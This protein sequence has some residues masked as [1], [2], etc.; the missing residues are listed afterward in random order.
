MVTTAVIP[1]SATTYATPDQLYSATTTSLQQ[2]VSDGAFTNTLRG[3]G[4]SQLSNADALSVTSTAPTIVSPT[5][6]SSGSQDSLSGGDVAGIVVLVVFAVF[7]GLAGALYY[8]FRTNPKAQ[9][10][11]STFLPSSA[12]GKATVKTGGNVDRAGVENPAAAKRQTTENPAATKNRDSNWKDKTTQDRRKF[13][14]DQILDD[15]INL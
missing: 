13:T 9:G 10:M 2:S 8:C 5:S 11:F 12:S 15:S 6:S 3:S 4:D 7:A 14:K 1:L